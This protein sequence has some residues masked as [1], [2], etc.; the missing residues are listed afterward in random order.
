M[1]VLSTASEIFDHLGG[2]KNVA[3]I[4]GVSYTCAHNWKSF[5]R[6]PP[7]TYLRLTTALRKRGAKAPPS[8][9]GMGEQESA[10]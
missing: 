3:V 5:N 10:A 2:T 4:A 8:L 1:V 9:W 7:R 6:F